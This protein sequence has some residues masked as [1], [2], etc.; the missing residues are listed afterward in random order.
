MGLSFVKKKN[1]QQTILNE[2]SRNYFL[3]SRNRAHEPTGIKRLVSYV[4]DTDNIYR[5]Q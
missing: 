4:R 2:N 3:F 1:K 5:H